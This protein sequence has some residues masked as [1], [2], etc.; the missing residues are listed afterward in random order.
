MA[1]GLGIGIA[2]T[3]TVGACAR[4]DDADP[5]SV[6]CRSE[7]APAGS[8]GPSCLP[9]RGATLVTDGRSHARRWSGSFAS[10][11]LRGWDQLQAAP[12]AL[13]IV[14]GP[15]AGGR[16]VALFTVRPGDRP[17]PGGERAEV[18]ASPRATG[19]SE[20]MTA[21]YAWSTYFPR[22]LNPVPD[23]TWNVFTQW[24]GTQPDGCSPN[25]ALQVN[26]RARP[27]RIRLSVRGGRLG[28]GCSAQ[29]TRSWD[30]VALPR[31]RWVDFALLVRWSADPR[32]GFVKLVVDGRVVVPGTATPTLYPRQGVYAKQGFYRGPSSRTSRIYQGGMTRFQ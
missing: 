7:R 25:V 2:L 14:R 18:A 29:V 28:A 19:G 24:H 20:G 17:V 21:W 32:R 26:T 22:D 11:R 10:T 1:T 31:R 3:A 12:G 16:R 23:H 6:R 5:A 30:T 4:D 13:R 8:A 27:A 15:R 9:A